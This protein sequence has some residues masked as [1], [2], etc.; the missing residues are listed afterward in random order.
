M[1]F[2]W[3]SVLALTA[4]CACGSNGA[5]Q[6]AGGAA[7]A[8]ET[9]RMA[10]VVEKYKKQQILSGFDIKGTTLV[11]F[12]DTEKYSQLD[13]S[14]EAAMKSELLNTWAGAWKS[15]HLRQHA[16]LRVIFQNYYGQEMAQL[17]KHV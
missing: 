4:L 17:Q 8:G 2:R 13:D 5:K 11:V 6:I 3:L 7:A 9:T 1:S 16:T 12:A 10:P 14:V 15:D